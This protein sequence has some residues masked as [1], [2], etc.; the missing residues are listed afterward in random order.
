MPYKYSEKKRENDRAYKKT[1]AGRASTK[2][3]HSKRYNLVCSH[4]KSAFSGSYYQYKHQKYNGGR[5]CC[6]EA[7][8]RATIHGLFTKAVPELGPCPTCGEKFR[9]RRQEKIFCSMKCYTSSEQFKKMVSENRHKIAEAAGARAGSFR[10]GTTIK[11]LECGADVYQKKSQKKKFCSFV[12][13]RA[14][15]AARFDRWVANPESIALPQCYDEFLDREELPCLVEGCDWTG[16]HLTLHTNYAHG[17]PARDFKRAVG[18][19]LKTGVISRDLAEAYQR[20]EYQ[21]VAS[22]PEEERLRVQAMLA[23][24]RTPPDVVYVSLER[25]EHSRK[26]RMFLPPGPEKN[27]EGCGRVYQMKQPSGVQKYCSIKCRDAEYSRKNKA[28]P[29]PEKNCEECGSVYQVK[30]SSGVQKY[31]SRKCRSAEYSRKRK[32][33]VNGSIA[34]KG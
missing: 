20:R 26:A 19:N 13:Y 11:C 10:T 3:L 14:Y 18:F 33:K 27:C 9:S 8:R 29:K 23:V 1:E 17:V 28:P 2:S 25:R 31:C 24:D 21:G 6:S 16:K 5:A 22:W 34:I 32:A 15:M 7:C 30:A 12:C 4:C